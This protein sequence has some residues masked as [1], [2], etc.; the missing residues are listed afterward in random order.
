MLTAFGPPSQIAKAIELAK[1]KVLE[2]QRWP[3]TDDVDTP[4]TDFDFVPAPQQGGGRK[5]TRCS[6]PSV[7][8]PPHP[9]EPAVATAPQPPAPS[10]P[11]S[12]APSAPQ[13]PPAPPVPNGWVL[14][15]QMLQFQQ[16]QTAVQMIQF[17]QQNMVAMQ[18]MQMA[19]MQSVAPAPGLQPPPTQ[20]VPENLPQ[21]AMPKRAPKKLLL[22]HAPKTPPRWP[23]ES[24]DTRWLDSSTEESGDDNMGKALTEIQLWSIGWLDKRCQYS[25]EFG[26]MAAEMDERAG[27]FKGLNRYDYRCY[28][29]CREFIGLGV[30]TSTAASM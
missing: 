14:Q 9:P 29:D 22:T 8:K 4:G 26:V 15:N 16:M 28:V 21:R 30:L 24:G 5:R 13:P 7:A 20:P 11:Q 6:A 25:K 23:D 19:P 17:H 27:E 18:Q 12:P 2:S 10:A 3:S 1:Q